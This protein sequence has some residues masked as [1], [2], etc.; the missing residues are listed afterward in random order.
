MQLLER[1]EQ[2]EIAL[3][4]IT[5]EAQT[6]NVNSDDIYEVYPDDGHYHLG[7][8]V[9]SVLHDQ[10]NGST[11]TSMSIDDLKS[12]HWATLLSAMKSTN[13]Y[14][15]MDRICA[16]MNVLSGNRRILE[17]CHVDI[18]FKG[19][20]PLRLRLFEGNLTDSGLGWKTWGA[21][22]LMSK[23]IIS[24]RM[25]T[26][27][28]AKSVLELGCG[29][30]LVGQAVKMIYDSEGYSNERMVLSDFNDQVLHNVRKSLSV[31]NLSCDVVK[32]DWTNYKACESLKENSFDIIIASDVVY[33]DSHSKMVPE[34]CN[35]FLKLSNASRF[36]VTIP[37]RPS[38]SK[39]IQ[40]FDHG[41]IMNGFMLDECRTFFDF[42]DTSSHMDL[43]F[44]P[45]EN[46]KMVNYGCFYSARVY[47]RDLP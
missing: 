24:R 22:V 23:L 11:D 25:F 44:V 6:R 28:S 40:A 18:H 1:L 46:S 13:N 10:D 39:E 30:G 35:H 32:L 16:L 4:R 2:I 21:S 17:D 45:L 12:E 27:P 43:S 38:L 26:F 3:E 47:K 37:L 7:D 36:Y 8:D 31:N 33:E 9:G 42:Y 20:I 29:T 5:S 15:L 19:P 41:M 14:E 34:V